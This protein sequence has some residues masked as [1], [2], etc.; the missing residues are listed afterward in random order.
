MW[1]PMY[2]ALYSTALFILQAECSLVKCC[3]SPHSTVLRLYGAGL[4]RYA[5][6]SVL[7][8]WVVA[9]RYAYDNTP[10]TRTY[11]LSDLGVIQKY[12]NN[13]ISDYHLY[14]FSISGFF[15]DDHVHKFIAKKRS[16]YYLQ[17]GPRWSLYSIRAF[18]LKWIRSSRM[19]KRLNGMSQRLSFFSGWVTLLH[20]HIFKATRFRLIL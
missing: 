9:T 19:P 14:F 4:R 15:G 20:S 10:E 8:M 17:V 12:R 7:S 2:K 6:S 13:F 5:G 18:A 3:R 11:Q 1:L 16:N